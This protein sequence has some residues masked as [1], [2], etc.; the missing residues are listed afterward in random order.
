MLLIIAVLLAIIAFPTFMA[1]M[2]YLALLGLV[3]AGLLLTAGVAVLSQEGRPSCS[4]H[5]PW[6]CWSARAVGIAARARHRRGA[7]CGPQDSDPPCLAYVWTP[8]GHSTVQCAP[9]T[10]QVDEL[11][12]G[13]FELSSTAPRD[14]RRRL[15]KWTVHWPRRVG[16]QKLGTD[17]TI[18]R[19][20]DPLWQSWHKPCD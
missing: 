19:P 3:G 10:V 8:A 2:G 18:R 20:C 16:H 12:H 4:G 6:T 14:V 11:T 9:Y 1:A 15:P 13:F 17:S 5:L 7:R